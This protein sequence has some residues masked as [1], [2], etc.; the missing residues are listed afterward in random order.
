MVPA[1]WA[2]E[3]AV[4]DVALSAV[5]AA[6]AVPKS[7]AVAFER[8]VPVIVTDVLPAVG[9]VDGLMAV[10][11]GGE[12]NVNWSAELVVLVP[13]GV[14]TVMSA[15][16][17]E[18]AGEVAVICVPLLTVNEVAVL[19]P[20]LTPVAPVK[21]VPVIVTDVPPAVDPE[22]GLT[23]DTAG[24]GSYVNWSALEVA[25][26]PPGVVTVTWTV[27]AMPA[28]ETAEID[29]EL[30]TTTPVAALAP[31]LTVAPETKPVPVIVTD[32]VPANGP[33]AGVTPVTVGTGS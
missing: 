9:P 20:T 15:V 33:S 16:P 28:G 8:L 22:D 17:A 14:V 31:K 11:V 29:V 32:W 26:V 30:F 1:E 5:I 7:T 2:G 10:T 19:V 12:T 6:A 3:V 4:I 21:L 24:A 23:L 18:P 25:L 13:D 27:P